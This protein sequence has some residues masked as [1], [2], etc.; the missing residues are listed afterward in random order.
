[1]KFPF[2]HFASA[3]L[4]APPRSAQL[5]PPPPYPRRSRPIPHRSRPD[6]APTRGGFDSQSRIWSVA[7][8][9]GTRARLRRRR[10]HS[11]ATAWIPSTTAVPRRSPVQPPATDPLPA[12]FRAWRRRPP[13]EPVC[14]EGRP[15]AGASSTTHEYHFSATATA[16]AQVKKSIF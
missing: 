3:A 15:K 1:M 10:E 14:S 11:P 9:G 8:R 7:R 2:P 4:G 5:S 13:Q 16:K 6:S 12:S